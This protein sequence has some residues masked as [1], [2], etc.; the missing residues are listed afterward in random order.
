MLF[1]LC[2]TRAAVFRQYPVGKQLWYSNA[3]TINFHLPAMQKY[4]GLL[5]HQSHDDDGIIEVV[6]ADG[7]RTLHFGSPPKQSCMKISDPDTLQSPY[8]RAM[9]I[10]QL[11]LDSFDRALMIGL[12]GGCLAKYLL[13]T[14]PEGHIEAIE[15]RAGVVD[16][17]RSH[18][19][20][21]ADP[22]LKVRIGDGGRYVRQLAGRQDSHYD[23][24]LIDAFDH[25]A[26][27][28]AVNSAAFFDACRQSLAPRG[29]L[30]MNLWGSDKKAFEQS[31]WHLGRSFHWQLLF[32]PVRA[33]GN[34]I[35]LGFPETYTGTTLAALRA[36]AQ[37]LEEYSRIEFPVFLNDL[38]KHN[39]ERFFSV[40]KK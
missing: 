17:A 10:W 5:V 24:L 14:F 13:R 4:G 37:L 33:R 23:L 36:R 3:P 18:F 29:M 15:Y 12:G 27:S 21:P 32:L 30:V 11:F 7:L 19:G 26:M 20:L 31:A 8:V 9:L 6:E 28:S 35:A 2:L 39:A 34:I 22:R 16:I 1:F 25:D 40:I 38:K